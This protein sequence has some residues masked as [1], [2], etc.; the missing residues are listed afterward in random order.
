[1]RRTLFFIG[2]LAAML[3]SLP[4]MQAAN[5]VVTATPWPLQESSKD[6]VLTFHADRGNCGLSGLPSN[7]EVYAHIGVITNLSKNDG[8]WK[9]APSKWTLNEDH[10]KLT[11]VGTG[12]DW[13]LNIGDIRSYFKI[14]NANEHVKKIA[15]VF[16]TADC[17]REGKDTGNKD[18]FVEVMEE[19]LQVN[20][21]SD[22]ANPVMISKTKVNFTASS[23]KT[24]DIT[25]DVD[26]KKIGEKSDVNELSAGYEFS[27]AGVY[28]VTATVTS[29]GETAKSSMEVQYI[30]PSEAKAFPGGTPRMGYTENNDGS[31]TFCIAA[32]GKTSMNI[33]GSWDDFKVADSNRMYYQ[34]YE[35][36]R[37]FW[38]TVS[39]LKKGESY[40]YYYLVDGVKGVSDPYA[41]LVLDPYND[42]YLDLS[43]FQGCPAYPASLSGS[44]IPLTVY[45]PGGWE[46][47]WEVEKFNIPD[48]NQLVIYEL[49]FRDFTGTE[50]AANGNGT[51]AAAIE[52]IPYLKE[53]GVNAVELMP[54]ME[55]NGN[56]SWG[57]NTNFYFAPDKAYGTPVDYKKFIDECHKAGMAVI[58]DIVLNQSDWLHP[59]YQ[60]YGGTANNPF[61][62]ATAP[63]D[64]SVLND[65][66]QDN[67]LVEQQWTDALKFWMKE[68]NVDGFRFDLVKGLG[69]NESYKTSG[70]DGYNTSRVARMKRLHAAIK[71]V[72]PRGLHINEN[73]AGNKEENDMGADGQL[74]WSNLNWQTGQYVKVEADQ[75]SLAGFLAEK[76]G[77]TA[78]TTVS[79]MESHDEQR[80]AYMA[81]EAANV[82]I[83]KNT[84]NAYRRIGSAAAQM[85]L[86]PGAKMIWQFGELA[87]DQN[88]KNS[89][90]NDTGNK[91][92]MWESYL[93]DSRRMGL[94]DT[95]RD[96]IAIRRANPEL[97]DGSAEFTTEGME[98]DVKKAR[99]ITLRKGDREVVALINPTTSSM[100]IK[101]STSEINASNAKVLAKS[102]YS[103]FVPEVTDAGDGIKVTVPGNCF[104][105]LGSK[106]VT[107]GIDSIGADDGEGERTWS[108]AG[109]NGCVTVYG[110]YNRAEV[111]DLS[112]RRQNMTGLQAGIYIVSVDGEAVKVVVR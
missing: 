67:T 81:K 68:Y 31:V 70:T 32:P 100:D 13:T 40:L 91:K 103:A 39:G 19:G 78:G 43:Q 18:I 23:T 45:R 80:V 55:F 20:L 35:G 108:V 58:L 84:T 26:G 87:D 110:E 3:L 51:V 47:D 64:Y 49:L 17:S 65:W 30:N 25:I 98:D 48:P 73:L 46:Y 27:E 50:G 101:A 11:R 79:Y 96:L 24:G 94:H 77:R 95:Y 9:Y 83:S 85:L 97:F 61:Y 104:V 63:H 36:N 44:D 12:N 88:T 109:G 42:S 74:N 22:L 60:M 107:S 54:I 102:F 90:G 2:L 105:A 37:Y 15:V 82:A 57:Y 59:W 33:V 28:V 16:R 99:I 92:V 21:S 10:R 71:E 4:T 1:M 106:A 93:N 62:N 112:G 89:G 6:V 5:E 111:Y 76:W 72:N 86:T 53:L 38:I 29:D 8:D 52:R 41:Q 69:D 56:L 34:D 66:N 7:A 75:S 14:N